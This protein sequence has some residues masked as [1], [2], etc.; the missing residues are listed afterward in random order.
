M[1]G[2]KGFT[3][4]KAI[5]NP[6]AKLQKSAFIRVHPS[7]H[8]HLTEPSPSAMANGSCGASLWENAFAEDGP[9][10]AVRLPQ[11]LRADPGTQARIACSSGPTPMIAII[12][13]IL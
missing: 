3:D 4:A 1:S 12:R 6:P 5:S 13:L 8:H 2:Q 9:T 11:G 7:R 10:C